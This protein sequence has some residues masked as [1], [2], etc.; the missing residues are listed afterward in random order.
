MKLI[1]MNAI[2]LIYLFMKYGFIVYFTLN[3][4]TSFIHIEMILSLLMF[5][6]VP[7]FRFILPHAFAT[8]IN[9]WRTCSSLFIFHGNTF[10]CIF[11]FCWCQFYCKISRYIVYYVQNAANLLQHSLT[12]LY[13]TIHQISIV[14]IQCD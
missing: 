2:Y 3:L 7:F 13:F 10:S 5:L 1:F 11:L 4:S 12:K 9:I 14:F 6:F 8:V